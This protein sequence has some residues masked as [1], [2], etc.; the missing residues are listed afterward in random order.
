M[1]LYCSLCSHFAGEQYIT[2]LQLCRVVFVHVVV[3]FTVQPGMLE[4]TLFTYCCADSGISTYVIVLCSLHL[5]MLGTTYM[6]H[7]QA[8]TGIHICDSILLFAIRMLEYN[9][10]SCYSC[11]DSGIHTCSCT[12]LFDLR[13]AGYKTFTCLVFTYVITYCLAWT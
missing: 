5:G 3:L 12:V 4:Y 10:L 6:H 9:A 1:W 13:N 11:V 8:V 7:P 2:M